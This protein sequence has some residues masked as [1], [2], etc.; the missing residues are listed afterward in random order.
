MILKV[1]TDWFRDAE[2]RIPKIER[3]RCETCKTTMY[4]NKGR[5]DWACN[6]CDDYNFWMFEAPYQGFPWD[7]EEYE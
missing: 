5:Q 3:P 2:E 4:W 6:P 1:I 7:D